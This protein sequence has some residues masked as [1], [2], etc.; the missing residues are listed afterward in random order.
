MSIIERLLHTAEH[1]RLHSDIKALLR[2]AANEIAALKSRI[3]VKRNG[4]DDDDQ[5][6]FLFTRD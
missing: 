3:E 4:R 2:E 1:E 6:K 5:Q